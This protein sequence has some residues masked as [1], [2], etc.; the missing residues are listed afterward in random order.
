MKP[1]SGGSSGRGSHVRPLVLQRPAGAFSK[2]R[3]KDRCRRRSTRAR[4]NLLPQAPDHE[5]ARDASTAMRPPGTSM[6]PFDRPVP[7]RYASDD[8]DNPDHAPEMRGDVVCI[9]E[10][11]AGSCAARRDLPYRR[12][13]F[14]PKVAEHHGRIVKNTGDDVLI[15]VAS[16][17]RSADQ[18]ID[19]P[20]DGGAIFDAYLQSLTD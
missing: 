15:G 11:H 14:D 7:K 12:S 1:A 2:F 16:R 13:I 8:P 19:L 6:P 5:W 10:T 17:R 18:A 4:R 20:S 9:A 3:R